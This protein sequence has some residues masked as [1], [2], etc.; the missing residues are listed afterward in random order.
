MRACDRHAGRVVGG[1]GSGSSSTSRS[2]AA[3]RPPSPSRRCAPGPTTRSASTPPSSPPSKPRP[4]SLAISCRRPRLVDQ[5]PGR[6]CLR[7]ARNV[8]AVP[9]T[10]RHRSLGSKHRQVRRRSGGSQAQVRVCR[11]SASPFYRGSAG[12][13]LDNRVSPRAAGFVRT[14]R[15]ARLPSSRLRRLP[16][17][18]L[19]TAGS[20]RPAIADEASPPHAWGDSWS[21]VLSTTERSNRCRACWTNRRHRGGATDAE[22]VANDSPS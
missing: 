16:S 2:R 9:R 11:H 13:N 10:I 5:K 1:A 6:R 3:G 8:S 4:A 20:P 14:L 21:P 19:V 17:R 12:L 7:C 18:S 22:E 15:V